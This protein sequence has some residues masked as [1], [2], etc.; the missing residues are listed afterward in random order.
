MNNFH[1]LLLIPSVLSFLLTCHSGRVPVVCPQ[2]EEWCSGG[3]ED[4]G[5]S[6]SSLSDRPADLTPPPGNLYPCPQRKGKRTLELMFQL[7]NC[8]YIFITLTF[9]HSARYE[10]LLY[11]LFWHYCKCTCSSKLCFK[12]IMENYTYMYK[13]KCCDNDTTLFH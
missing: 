2:T 10:I 1:A 3:H 4:S 6:G 13:Y 5:G 12:L 7:I 11:V 8:I 9:Y